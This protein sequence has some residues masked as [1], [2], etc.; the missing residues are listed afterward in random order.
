MSADCG[1]LI[2][3]IAEVEFGARVASL[4]EF[5]HL[6]GVYNDPFLL[7]DTLRRPNILILYT[8]QQ[9]WD[10][11]GAN[12]NAD[13]RTPHLDRLAAAGV[14]F[15]RYFVQNPVCMPSRLSFLTGQYPGTL[16]VTHMGVPVPS[17]T[18]TLP[19]L[20][21]GYGYTSANIGKLHFLPHA[22]RDH[23]EPHPDYGFDHLEISDE[24]GSYE[25]AYR[26]WVRRKAPDQLD[27]ISLGEAPSAIDWKKAM[28]IDDGIVHPQERFLKKALPFPGRS[29]VTHSAF[30]AEQTMQFISNNQ[31]QPFLCISGFYP[32]HSP[33]VAPQEYLDLYD[34]A[35]LTIPTF[36]AEIDAR[37]S[38][39]AFSEHELR[40][41]HHGYYAMIS[42]VD[43]WVGRI[44]AHLDDLRLSDETI[45]VFTSDHGEWL[46]E[47]L[48][49]GKGYPGHDCVTRVPLI[50]R[51]PA[52]VTGPGRTVS[53]IC[54]GVDVVPTLLA[55]AGVQTP[56]HLQGQSLLPALEGGD[57]TTRGAALT[58]MHGWKTLRT[59]KLRY[60]VEA[61]G[62]EMLF[63]L[64]VDPHGYV[65]V[66]AE[67]A[68]AGALAEVRHRLLQRLL[69]RE[70]PRPRLW[71]Y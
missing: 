36:P 53:D 40:G 41:A 64:D 65:D 9:R 52:A 7:E 57:T 13:I 35:Q 70:R 24:P 33:W 43:D 15:D 46:G 48:K 60:V 31:Q 6:D 17:D 12:G 3:N 45:V 23:R 44:L 66:S 34:P 29:D 63:D 55:A 19:R 58:E 10:A 61:D 11:I 50:I 4:V 38:A 51:W 20:L 22:N 5:L 1:S 68:Y 56:G 71:P 62:A 42:E 47:H 14:N 32:P 16:G 39:D 2:N 28:S 67:E 69:D 37:R 30:V 21:Q 54:E 26:A 8:D 25:D 18:V 27:Y 49:Y 59:D